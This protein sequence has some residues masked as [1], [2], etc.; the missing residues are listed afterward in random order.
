MS[1]GNVEI[2]Q[3]LFP[4]NRALD[5]HAITK[6]RDEVRAAFAPLIAKGFSVRF[7]APGLTGIFRGPNAMADA[8]RDYLTAFVKHR[9]VFERY[10]DNGDVVVALGQQHVQIET[11]RFEFNQESGLVFFFDDDRKLTRIEGYQ[12][13]DEALK[14]AGLSE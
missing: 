8:M 10:I 4:P 6:H 1:Q 3:S 11:N 5:G 13:W 7:V 12:R 2:V 9:T 14:A